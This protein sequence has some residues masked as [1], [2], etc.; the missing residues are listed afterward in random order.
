VDPAGRRGA[1]PLRPDRA[2]WSVGTSDVCPESSRRPRR[3][4]VAAATIGAIGV[5]FGDIGTS[6]IYT[7]KPSSIRRTHTLPDPL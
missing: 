6:P 2:R 7:S 4:G 1:A 3:A 5:V